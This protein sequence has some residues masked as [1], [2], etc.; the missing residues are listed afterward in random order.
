MTSASWHARIS[1]GR[2]TGA[3]FLV[4]DRHV[5]TCA[6]VVAR[7]GTDTVAVSFAHGAHGAYGAEGKVPAQ[8]IVQGGWDGRETDPG[9]LAVLELDRPVPLKPA[10][11]AAP[12]DAYGDPP[13]R[14]LAYGFPK[15]Q[16]EGTLAEYRATAD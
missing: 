2:D 11:F 4:T 13:R 3:G 12:S 10:E 9:D 8:V 6:H 15:R 5:L 16:E 7:S 14:L 1:C